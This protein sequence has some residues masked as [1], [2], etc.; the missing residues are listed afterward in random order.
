MKTIA[1]MIFQVYALCDPGG[2]Y[3]ASLAF[4]QS[5]MISKFR[6]CLITSEFALKACCSSL[7][8]REMTLTSAW[9]SNVLPQVT[10]TVHVVRMSHMRMVY[11]LLGNGMILLKAG[12]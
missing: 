9:H 4:A 2:L 3:L 1:V 10:E 5:R 7:Y 12:A 11:I 8:S 6:H